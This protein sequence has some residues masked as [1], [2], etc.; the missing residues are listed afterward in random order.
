MKKRR[1][2]TGEESTIFL[3]A[4]KGL[5]ESSKTKIYGWNVILFCPRLNEN[6]S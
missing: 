1:A 4:I 5:S 2:K 6:R 3:V